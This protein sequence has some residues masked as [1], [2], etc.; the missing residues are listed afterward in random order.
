MFALPYQ[1]CW[2]LLRQSIAFLYI[3]DVISRKN[4]N[5][6]GLVMPNFYGQQKRG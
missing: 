4:E 5:T 2:L 6:L 3:N 1:G